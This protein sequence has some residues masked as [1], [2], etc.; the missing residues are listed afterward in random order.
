MNHPTTRQGEPE[1]KWTRATPAVAGF[2]LIELLVVIAII[3]IL[4]AMLLPG[5]SRAK[6]QGLSTSC[7]N[8][9]KQLDLA[10]LSYAPDYQYKMPPNWVRAV[11]AWIDGDIG[12][13]STPQGVTNLQP[14][15]KGL[16]YPYC[17]NYHIYQCPANIEGSILDTQLPRVVMIR[18]YSIEGRMGGANDPESP[19]GTSG[20]LGTAY[21]EYSKLDQVM[22]PAP[23]Q[24]I[25][26]VDESCN[27][28][29]DGFFAIQTSTT[30]WQ[31]SPT[32][33]HLKGTQFGFAD[34]HAEHWTWRTLTGEQHL[35]APVI[36]SG[37]STESD[38]IRVQNAVFLPKP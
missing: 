9:I 18:N 38:L 21:P 3:A 8:N 14:I 22:W 1:Q 23:T 27:T 31:N 17:P 4:A 28:I 19:S 24:A 5:L 26:F 37:V 10:W 29:D 13:V 36:S 6:M 32:G 34:G 35:N 25:N 20:I 33:R 30:E 15:V 12:D 16:L 11:D 7:M 2:T